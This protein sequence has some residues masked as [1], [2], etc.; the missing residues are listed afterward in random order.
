MEQL[1]E[2]TNFLRTALLDRTVGAISVSSAR[3]VA[4]VVARLPKDAKLV[5]EYGP[6]DGVFT[7]ALLGALPPNARLIVV[8][9]NNDFVRILK[10]ITDP[11]LFVI[12][13]KAEELSE[14]ELTEFNGADMLVASM[15][16]SF[17]TPIERNK[18]VADAFH[19]LAP[20]GRFVISHQY[21]WLMREPLRKV[22]RTVSLSFE[23][24]NIFPCFVIE[25]R[26]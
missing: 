9:P 21:S 19:F 22:F 16:F 6:G 17:L 12:S 20:E 8:E 26:K 4:D 23:I 11:R 1:R 10:G 25:A 5:I 24:R 14:G 18:V 3:V 7:R 13:G 2:R 15:P